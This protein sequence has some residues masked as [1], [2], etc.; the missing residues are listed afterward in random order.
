MHSKFCLKWLSIVYKWM[1]VLIM[2]CTN[3]EELGLPP[4]DSSL[5]QKTNLTEF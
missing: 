3:R 1:N 4:L 5:T 2:R